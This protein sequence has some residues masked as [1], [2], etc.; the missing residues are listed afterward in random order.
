MN[1]H[2][3]KLCEACKRPLSGMSRY[4]TRRFCSPEC[5][6]TTPAKGSPATGTQHK[7]KRR[8]MVIFDED[9]F[10]EIRERA[11]TEKTS[12]AAQVRLLCEWGLEA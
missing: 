9:Q 7:A 6:W 5:Y 3:P 4:N 2:G 11:V 12:F 10:H 8:A 1:A